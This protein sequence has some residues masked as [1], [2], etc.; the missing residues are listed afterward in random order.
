MAEQ[1]VDCLV[2]KLVVMWVASMVVSMVGT[3]A[4]YWVVD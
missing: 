1:K 2:E 4:V 3:M